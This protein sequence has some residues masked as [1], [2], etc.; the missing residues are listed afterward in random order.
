MKLDVNFDYSKLHSISTEGREKLD[1]IKPTNLAYERGILV[2]NSFRSSVRNV[3]AAGDCAEFIQPEDGEL[4]IEQLWYT[5]KKQGEVVGDVI[6]GKQRSYHRGIW[7]NSAKFF[8]VLI[9]T[10]VKLPSPGPSSTK[11]NTL[12]LPIFSQAEINHMPIISENRFEIVGDVIKSPF[13]P[14]GSLLE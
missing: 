14:N 12:G 2:D 11:L 10:L 4:K 9:I 1:L 7:F 5:G 3:F 13:L 6:S 8:K